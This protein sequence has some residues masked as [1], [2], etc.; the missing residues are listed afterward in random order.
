M[1]DIISNRR[2]ELGLT[3]QQLAEKLNVTDKVVSKWET[4]RC[5]PDTSMLLQLADVLGISVND[6]LNEN[7]ENQK[8]IKQ[9]IKHEVNAKY[10]NVY[11]I[12]M[13]I[14]FAA[15][16]FMI[17]GRIMWDEFNHY[18]NNSLELPSYIFMIL[19]VLIEIA[20]I[21][22]YLVMR[23]NL[24]NKYSASAVFD[25]KYINYILFS[26]YPL[27]FIA[28]AVFIVLHGLSTTEQLITLII[29]AFI[30]L[31]PFGACYIWNKKRKA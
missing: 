18:G 27:F 24:L 7:A 17:V 11:I 1:K 28:I 19:A 6:L 26:T 5:L 3:Q 15:L 13:T 20:A 8:S 14:Q 10:K 9:T 22:F 21:S 2:K 12:T 23:N 25:K 29:A 16:I 31:I 30:A 4:G